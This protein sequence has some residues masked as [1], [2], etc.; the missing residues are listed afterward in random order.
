[1]PN[2]KP[3][4]DLRKYNGVLK[5][6]G[7]GRHVFL[8]KNGKE[9]YAILDMREFMRIQATVMLLTDLVK[10]EKSA[11]ADGWITANEIERDLGL[12]REQGELFA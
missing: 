5:D 3:V 8:T 12:A 6:I 7:I 9:R 1:M 11:S 10:G 2:I 4:S